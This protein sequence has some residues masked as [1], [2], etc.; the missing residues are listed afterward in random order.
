[1]S[2]FIKIIINKTR[3]EFRNIEYLPQIISLYERFSRYLNDDYFLEKKSAMDAVIELV[4]KTAPYFWVIIH[5]K[6]GILAGFVFLDNWVGAKASFTVRKLQPAL[7]RN[8]GANT[9]NSV[10]E[11]L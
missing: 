5:K 10:Q 7:T 3:K 11:N 9:L 1:M 8:T 2:K 4:E 6:S